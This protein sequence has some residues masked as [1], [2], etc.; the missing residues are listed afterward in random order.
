MLLM[1]AYRMD[2]RI[3]LRL[4]QPEHADELFA[5]VDQNRDYLRR[6][7]PWLDN[8]RSPEDVRAFIQSGL[9]QWAN[10]N[11]FQAGIGYRL[12]ISQPARLVGCIGYHYWDWVTRRTEIGYWLDSAH[13]GKG[14][15]TRACRALIEYAFRDL[16]LNPVE[17]RCAVNNTPS[18]AIPERR[19][20]TR[21]EVIRQ[22][23]CMIISSIMSWMA[24]WRASG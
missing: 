21:E 6:W 17:I 19:R 1:F 24:C 10:N 15:M 8:E 23:G 11:G 22:A 20:F 16:K 5:L 2:D 14:I 13:Q 3:E 12:E 7:L 9:Q 18:C 4:L